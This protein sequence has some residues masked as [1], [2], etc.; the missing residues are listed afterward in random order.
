[1]SGFIRPL[2]REPSPPGRWL[3]WGVVLV[4]MWRRWGSWGRWKG[5]NLTLR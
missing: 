2:Q 5:N 3:G 1:M 4:G